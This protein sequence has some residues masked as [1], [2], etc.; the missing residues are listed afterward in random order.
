MK[1]E[2]AEE[3]VKAEREAAAKSYEEAAELERRVAA[4]YQAGARRVPEGD[5]DG[6]QDVSPAR[7]VPWPAAPQE[8]KY[9]RE[10]GRFVRS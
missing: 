7:R 5:Y 1:A 6:V 3:A 2:A 9:D 10:T 4:A 8:T